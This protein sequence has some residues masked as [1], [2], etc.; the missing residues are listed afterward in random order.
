MTAEQVCIRRLIL[1]RCMS[2]CSAARGPRGI[3]A[4]DISVKIA[5]G[6]KRLGR[7]GRQ[8]EV[9]CPAN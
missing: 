3:S 9:V 7:C 5:S 6:V 1:E 8:L 4:E 2:D